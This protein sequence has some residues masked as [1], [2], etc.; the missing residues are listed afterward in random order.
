MS[1]FNRLIYFFFHCLY[2]TKKNLNS[3]FNIITFNLYIK[4]HFFLNKL[5]KICIYLSYYS[6]SWIYNII[7]YIIRKY[8]S[9]HKLELLFITSL[10][11]TNILTLFFIKLKLFFY[12]HILILFFPLRLLKLSI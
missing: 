9:D 1:Q 11:F 10:I 5:I 2:L 8:I 12:C 7:A 4:A 3:H 6:I